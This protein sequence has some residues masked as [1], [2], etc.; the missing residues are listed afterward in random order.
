MGAIRTESAKLT[1]MDAVQHEKS[2]VAGKKRHRPVDSLPPKKHGA[3]A[4]SSQKRAKSSAKAAKRHHKH[5]EAAARR[6][7]TALPWD[8]GPG[9]S[10]PRESWGDSQEW[11]MPLS[12]FQERGSSVPFDGRA[13]NY[14]SMP[15][16]DAAHVVH[17]PYDHGPTL[18]AWSFPA[19]IPSGAPPESIKTRLCS[20]WL[21]SAGCGRGEACSFAHG[22]LSSRATPD[23]IYF[24]NLLAMQARQSY[25]L[26]S[27][28]RG[29]GRYLRGAYP[30]TVVHSVVL[31]GSPTSPC[32]HPSR[33]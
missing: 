17:T 29:C 33:L 1:N 15:G 19:L 31:A 30:G 10:L 3:K 24:R 5:A 11:P 4:K 21:T 22:G 25:V 23:T 20:R 18:A 12:T 27:Q 8:R 32:L 9:P 28:T 13:S 14:W 6:I 7:H 26:R 2:Q 16:A